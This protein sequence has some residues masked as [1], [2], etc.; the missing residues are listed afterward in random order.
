MQ[1]LFAQLAVDFNKNAQWWLTREEEQLLEL[2]N[3]QHRNVSSIRDRILEALDLDYVN[4][5]GLPALT[6]TQL[7]QKLDIKN[8]TNSQC[9]ECASVLREFVGESKK[10]QGLYKWRI[11]F[12]NDDWEPLITLKTSSDDGF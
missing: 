8:P 2:H 12:R 5:S 1:Q 6:P 4:D 10:I 3:K 7:L 11:P 9:K